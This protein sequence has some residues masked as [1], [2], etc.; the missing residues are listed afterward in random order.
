M[1]TAII[2]CKH[3]LTDY[4]TQFSGSWNAIDTP[5]E[6]QDHEYCPECKRAIV[7][8]LLKIPKKYKWENLPTDE[9]T[10]EELLNIEKLEY[11]KTSELKGLLPLARRVFA[12]LYDSELNEYSKS[13]QVKHNGKVFYYFYWPSKPQEAKITVKTKVKID[14]ENI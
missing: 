13:G 1:R 7:E 8:T 10:L 11:E 5:K 12:N 3:C 4:T 6:Y 9:F 14:N 2:E